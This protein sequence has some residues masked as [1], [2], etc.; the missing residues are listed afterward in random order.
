MQGTPII[1]IFDF[2]AGTGYDSVNKKKSGRILGGRTYDEMPLI[3]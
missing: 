1:C 2:F 3:A